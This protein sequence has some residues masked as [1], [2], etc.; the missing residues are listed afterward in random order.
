MSMLRQ[1]PDLWRAVPLFGALGDPVRMQI[2]A[3]LCGRGPLSIARIAKGARISRQGMTKHLHV[4][5][6]AGLL[7]ASKRGREQIWQIK[8]EALAEAQHSLGLIASQWE[9]ALN[10]LKAFVERNP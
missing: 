8:P 6:S 2:V 5:E 9:G 1:N 3:R 10:R 7:A 4:L